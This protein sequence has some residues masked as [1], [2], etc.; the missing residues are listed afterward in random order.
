MDLYDLCH[1]RSLYAGLAFAAAPVCLMSFVSASPD[2]RQITSVQ[3]WNN[4][5]FIQNV[6]RET[7]QNT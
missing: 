1:M 7:T 5:T 6:G 4:F 3:H 2:G